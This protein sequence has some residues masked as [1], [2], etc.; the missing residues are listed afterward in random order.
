MKN[1]K[2]VLSVNE[3]SISFTQYIKGL[4]SRIIEPVKDLSLEVL[5]GEVHAI[6]GESGSGKSLLAHS[7][8]GILPGNSICKGK[9]K[10][11]GEELDQK[12][13]EKIRGKEIAF[14]PQSVN[15]LDPLMRVGKQIR[16]GINK[17]N[18]K[19]IEEHLLQKYELNKKDGEKYPFELS[20]GMLRRILF[21]TSI[22][23]GI[24]L[25]IA[26]EP[27]PGIHPEALS[28][29]LNEFRN[30]ADQG[31]A[32]LL[33]THDIISA[34]SISDKVT[35]LKDGRVVETSPAEYFR[36]D[37]ELLKEEYTRNLWKCLPIN[38]FYMAKEL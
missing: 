16:I 6:I 7:I 37:G 33:I 13:K 2:V 28:A 20:G 24:K 10:Y 30:I 23:D 15:Y 5:E 32:V 27:T 31:A 29:I 12:R 14:I 3:L 36:N 11:F 38:D 26:D 9:M 35:V 17:D 4:Q 25:V 34:L 8:L 18:S 21:A 19:E 22:R 1:K